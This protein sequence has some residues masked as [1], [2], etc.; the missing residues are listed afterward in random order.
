MPIPDPDK[1]WPEL[2]QLGVNEVRKRLSRG[3]Y[4]KYKIPVIEEWLR[5]KESEKAINKNSYR[6]G[7]LAKDSCD[8]ENE[9]SKGYSNGKVFL[10]IPYRNYE[11]C[12]NILQEVLVSAGL[13]P[14][15]AKG[16]VTS[17]AMLCKI[18]KLIKTCKYGIT[19]I[20]SGSNSVSYEYGLMHGFGMNVALLMRKETDKFSDI[21]GIEHLEYNDLRSFKVILAKW[22]IEN[23]SEVNKEILKKIIKEEEEALK[24]SDIRP[25]QTI[26]RLLNDSAGASEHIENSPTDKPSM[27]FQSGEVLGERKHN[28]GV[29][30]VIYQP[31]PLLYLRLIPK[32]VEPPLKRTEVK[33]IVFGIKVNPLRRNVGDGASWELNKYGGITY[34]FEKEPDGK[35]LFTTSQVFLNREIWGIDATV[36]SNRKIIP[37]VTLEL[38]FEVAL[39]HYLE[40]ATNLLNLKPPFIVEAGASDVKG[41]MMYMGHEYM[42]SNWGP[43][44]VDDIKKRHTL[45]SLKEI[46]VNDTLLAIFEEFF[47]AVGESRPKNFRGFPQND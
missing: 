13:T 17:Q 35:H 1:I 10:D 42:S 23:V 45:H 44:H 32:A 34:S 18:C 4:S 8:M 20:S 14:M 29:F 36:L 38:L 26:R 25:Y 15:I 47:D 3:A 28:G 41:Y 5:L 33:D 11:D 6:C 43:I 46:E 37:S 40:V 27:Y 30:K 2:D 21:T 19:D 39:K 22:L 12:E 7:V 31:T 9:I 16:K 24:N